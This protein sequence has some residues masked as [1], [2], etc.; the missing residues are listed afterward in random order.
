M[1]VAHV[2]WHNVQV[3]LR[4]PTRLRESAFRAKL[5][6]PQS[7]ERHSDVVRARHTELHVRSARQLSCLGEPFREGLRLQRLHIKDARRGRLRTFRPA[8]RLHEAYTLRG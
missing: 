8:Q 2:A 4:P 7:F 5:L 6:R 3:T 1:G